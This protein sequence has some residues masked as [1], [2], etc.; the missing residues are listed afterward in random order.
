MTWQAAELEN[1]K[2]CELKRAKAGTY[3]DPPGEPAG[4]TGPL[5]I[6]TVTNRQLHFLYFTLFIRSHTKAAALAQMRDGGVALLHT[7]KGVDMERWELAAAARV[8]G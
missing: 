1:S 5:M 2:P 8:G 6:T 7:S 4:Y 3:L